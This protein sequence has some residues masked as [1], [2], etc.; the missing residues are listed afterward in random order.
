M[1]PALAPEMWSGSSPWAKLDHVG[2]QRDTL[3]RWVLR[4]SPGIW[5]ARNTL[6]PC[7]TAPPS[8]LQLHR[9]AQSGLLLR[10]RHQEREQALGPWGHLQDTGSETE[11]GARRPT[12]PPPVPG[13]AHPRLP[14]G[15]PAHQACRA[16][17]RIQG[18]QECEPCALPAAELEGTA[19]GG[20][21]TGG[22]SFALRPASE[23]DFN[24]ED[25]MSLEAPRRRVALLFRGCHPPAQRGVGVWGSVNGG[26]R[27]NLARWRTRIK[28]GGRGPWKELSLWV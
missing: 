17:G 18:G 5:Q 24:S 27:G 10:Q 15:S 28:D 25:V 4:S 9:L 13:P 6:T 26:R 21:P 7:R 23:P 19:A 20:S 1:E 16:S 8:L 12:P 22:R 2:T 14:Q 3:G 11:L